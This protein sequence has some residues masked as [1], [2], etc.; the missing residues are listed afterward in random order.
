MEARTGH[1]AINLPDA[2]LGD[3]VKDARRNRSGTADFGLYAT[4][5]SVENCTTLFVWR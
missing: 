2:S 5:T 3:T 4:Y 1:L